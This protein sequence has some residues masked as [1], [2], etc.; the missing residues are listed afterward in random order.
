[1]LGAVF[2]LERENGW[3]QKSDLKTVMW[4]TGIS[5]AEQIIYVMTAD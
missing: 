2:V 4:N 5:L 1:M 3:K